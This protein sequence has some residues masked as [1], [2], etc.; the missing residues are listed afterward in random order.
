MD[1]ILHVWKAVTAGNWL[2][3]RADQQL[4][5]LRAYNATLSGNQLSVNVLVYGSAMHVLPRRLAVAKTLVRLIQFS[6][7]GSCSMAA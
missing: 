3:T 1:G 4:L 7:V 2:G 5:A 6:V